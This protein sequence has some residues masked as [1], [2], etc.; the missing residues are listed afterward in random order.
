MVGDAFDST[1]ALMLRDHSPINFVEQIEKPLLLTTGSL[2]KRVPQ[3]QMDSMATAMNDMNK[4][5][6]YFYYPEEGHDYVDPE[7]W[8]S[9]WAIAEQFL[10][11]HLGGYSEA[12]GE[13]F[14]LG[15]KVVVYK[16]NYIN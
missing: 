7:S 8:I 2:D 9:F 5:V 4:D 14:N 16:G 6:A 13:D 10:K 1:E 11:S 3:V 12:V 15:K